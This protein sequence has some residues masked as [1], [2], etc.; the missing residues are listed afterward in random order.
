MVGGSG[1]SHVGWPIIAL[2]GRKVR[3]E[4]NFETIHKILEKIGAD[5]GNTEE[6]CYNIAHLDGCAEGNDFTCEIDGR[7]FRFIHEDAIERIHRE[8]IEYFVDDCYLGGKE[9]PDVIRRYFDYDSFARDCRI[10]DGYGHHFAQYDG[11]ELEADG[12]YIFRVG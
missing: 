4:M 2:R 3:C 6:G 12:W 10:S 5:H 9:I 7:E 11:N 8:E 1:A